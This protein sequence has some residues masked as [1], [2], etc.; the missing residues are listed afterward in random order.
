[1]S[2][3]FSELVRVPH[4][5]FFTLEIDS[6]E[7]SVQDMRWASGTPAHTFRPVPFDGGQEFVSVDVK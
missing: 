3:T 5:Q 4:L 6:V 1:M 2:C 7:M